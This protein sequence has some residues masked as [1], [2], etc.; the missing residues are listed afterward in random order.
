MSNYTTLQAA[1]DAGITNMTTVFSG[2]RIDG[3]WGTLQT[4]IDWFKFNGAVL[5]S[6]YVHGNSFLGFN[7]Q[8]DNFSFFGESLSMISFL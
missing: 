3:G 1:I 5:S 4:G 7:S 6:I 8:S 2:S